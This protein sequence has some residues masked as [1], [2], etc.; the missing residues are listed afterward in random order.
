MEDDSAVRRT[1]QSSPPCPFI[2]STCSASS[3]RV[4]T[5]GVLYVWSL[6]ELST[7]VVSEKNSGM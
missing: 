3:I 6:R 5:A 2:H 7:A 4:A 1:A